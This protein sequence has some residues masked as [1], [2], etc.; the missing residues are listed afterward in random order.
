[1]RIGISADS[2]C[3]LSKEIIEKYNIHITPINIIVGGEEKKDGIDVTVPELFEYVEKTGELPKTSA[4][5]PEEYGE[6]FEKV[7]KECDFC[8]HF[9][10]SFGVSSTGT[11]ARLK[12]SQMENVYVI[13]SFNASVGISLLVMECVDRVRQG[14]EIKQIDRKSVV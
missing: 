9:A 5:N 3:D 13:D 8:L 4:L 7:L 10:L 14:M 11:N 6:H 2:T 1:M 12:A